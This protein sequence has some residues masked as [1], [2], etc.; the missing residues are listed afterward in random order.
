MRQLGINRRGPGGR[1]VEAVCTVRDAPVRGRVALGC[2][3]WPSV[4][5]QALWRCRGVLRG[6]CCTGHQL[7]T[8]WRPG[9]HMS[10]SC[11]AAALWSPRSFSQSTGH[12]IDHL[13]RHRDRLRRRHAHAR[14]WNGE[15]R[16]LL[17]LHHAL[18]LAWLCYQRPASSWGWCAG[19]ER[20]RNWWACTSSWTPRNRSV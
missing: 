19:I 11:R 16:C 13:R 12:V 18:S 7:S 3:G 1:T 8:R 15:G 4:A 10:C 5:F 17:H 20:A 6:R 9:V 2:A 14:I